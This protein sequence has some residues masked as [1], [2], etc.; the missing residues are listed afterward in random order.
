MAVFTRHL[1]KVAQS[2]FQSD[3]SY[4]PEILAVFLGGSRV[5]KQSVQSVLGSESK[6]S[7]YDSIVVVPSKH[8]IYSFLNDKQR[9]QLFANV[10]GIKKEAFVDLEVPSPSSP[11][12]S[13]FDAVGFAG[14]DSNGIE[15]SVRVLNLIDIFQ[16]ETT[17][18]LCYKDR[19]IFDAVGPEGKRPLL[20]QTT[21]IPHQLV[22]QHDQWVYV[23]SPSEVESSF[24]AFG[25]MSDLLFTSACI[26]D[27]G[28]YGYNIKKV[29]A[30]LYFAK[31]GSSPTLQ[32]F[33]R[34]PFFH[35]TYMNWL[36][37]ELNDLYAPLKANTSVPNTKIGNGDFKM[38]LGETYSTQAVIGLE[39]VLSSTTVVSDETV[40]QFNDGQIIPLQKHH[41]LKSASYIA[42]T[43]DGVE[44]FVKQM[45]FAK[46]EEYS[47]RLV[48]RFFSR[49]MKPRIAAKG[50][51]LYPLFR[52]TAK[53]HIRLSYI[54]SGYK[55]QDLERRLLHAEMVQAEDTLRA[56][57]QSLSL[58]RGNIDSADGLPRHSIQKSFYNRLVDDT[59]MCLHYGQGVKLPGVGHHISLDQLLTLRWRI[60]GE[61]YESLQ[62]AFDYARKLLR[63]SRHTCGH[64][65]WYSDSPVVTS[66]C[67]TRS[68]EKAGPVRSS[69]PILK[70]RDFI[71]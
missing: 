29:V 49:A 41:S 28:N 40:R 60:N 6:Q 52:G 30:E 9:R 20:V 10:V 69:L 3:P 39:N 63:P 51:L 43:Q 65:R 19:R 18:L 62:D 56:Y 48:A 17:N 24:A 55:D 32:S 1:Q 11:L 45:P 13:E 27:R 23:T 46:D 5:Y 33:C 50:E 22:I 66:C 4:L 59:W 61:C 53:S 8:D 14:Y 25:Y 58:A 54:R 12:W 42:K 71:Q 2:F 16:K 15:R 47:A 36:S 35:P 7:D 31:S 64:A 67:R 38:F 57:R 70:I 21:Y 26:Y 68:Q 34:H 37:H 44:I